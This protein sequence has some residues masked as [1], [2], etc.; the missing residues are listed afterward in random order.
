MHQLVIDRGLTA[1]ALLKPGLDTK[2]LGS[3]QRAEGQPGHLG[4]DLFPTRNGREY[5]LAIRVRG[6]IHTSNTSS[7]LRQISSD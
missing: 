1:I 3:A 6:R 5:L 7:N 4:P 2:H